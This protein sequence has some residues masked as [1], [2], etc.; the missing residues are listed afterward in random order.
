MSNGTTAALAL[1]LGAGAGF[2][3][4]HFTRDGK[5]KT[6]DPSAPESGTASTT[7]SD[8]TAGAT[9]TTATPPRKA[10][11][12]SLKLDKET[13][14]L[15]GERV[16]IPTAV[17]RCKAAGRA[18]LAVAANAPLAVNRE[19]YAALLSAGVPTVVKMP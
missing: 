5:K 16:D 2:A 3:I 12:C 7:P 19:L 6:S 1:A 8:A 13:L 11:P 17:A 14:T 9:A 18:E 10:G 15:E 4:Y